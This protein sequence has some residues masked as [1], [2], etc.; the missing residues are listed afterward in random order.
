MNFVYISGWP[1]ITEGHRAGIGIRSYD[2]NSPNERKTSA[3]VQSRILSLGND[4]AHSSISLL[5]SSKKIIFHINITSKL[6]IVHCLLL[7]WF[8]IPEN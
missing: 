4:A 8:Y 1:S 3:F 6:G 5:T 2:I 7:R